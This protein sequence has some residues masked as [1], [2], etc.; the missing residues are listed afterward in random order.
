MPRFQWNKLL[1]PSSPSV[2]NSSTDLDYVATDRQFVEGHLDPVYLLDV[3][4]HLIDF[5]EKLALLLG[6]SKEELFQHYAAFM[7][8]EEVERTLP[9]FH[10]VLQGS[11]ETYTVEVLHK[12]GRPLTLRV[13]NIPKFEHQLIVGVYGIARDITEDK[14]LRKQLEHLFIEREL[15]RDT[16]NLLSFTIQQDGHLTERNSSF[17]KSIGTNV[18]TLDQLIGFLHREDVLSFMTAY[19]EARTSEQ[20]EHAFSF[21]LGRANTESHYIGKFVGH[22]GMVRA[23]FS[24]ETQIVRLSEAYEESNERLQDLYKHSGASIY[25]R[26]LATGQLEFYTDEF[27]SLFGVTPDMMK[28]NPKA[29]HHVIHRNDRQKV[30]VAHDRADAGEEVRMYYRTVKDGQ[31][32]WIEERLVP[33]RNADG[34]VVSVISICY[35]AT[36]LKHQEEQIW[37]LAMYDSLTGLP[38]RSLFL[39]ELED[40]MDTYTHVAVLTLSFNSIHAINRDFG[41]AVGDDWIVATTSALLD[42]IP[43][44]SFVGHLGGD[45]YGILIPHCLEESEMVQYCQPLIRLNDQYIRV[46]PYEWCPSIS[47]GVSRYPEDTDVPVEL[48][49]Y[50]NTA[51]G[52]TQGT[53]MEPIVFYASN[54]NIDSYRRHQLGNDLRRAIEEHELFLEFQPKVDAWSGRIVGAEALVRWQHPEWGRIPPSDFIPLSEE[55]ELHIKLADWVLHETCRCLQAWQSQDLPVVP[56]SINISPKR[57]LHGN[58]AETVIRAL[59]RSN[60]PP[61]LLEI[62]ILETDVLSDNL[63]IHE[64]LDR[65]SDANIR[66][67]LDDFGTGYS[68]LSYLQRYP[69]KTIKIDQQF[70][71][72]LH[73]NKKTQSIV[74]TILF[75]ADEFGM[76]VVV[77]GVETLEQLMILRRLNCRIIQGYLFSRPLDIRNFESA[78]ENRF[79]STTETGP[80]VSRQSFSLDAAVTIHKLHDREVTVGSTPI[81]LTKSSLRSLHFYATVRLPIADTIEL[82]ITL[83]H[84][85]EQLALLVSPNSMI[86]LENGIFEYEASFLETGDAH[87]I[88]IAL[89]ERMNT[90]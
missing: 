7:T 14:Q 42:C 70:A 45:E 11:E 86:E 69:I 44:G 77:E 43:K 53:K 60:I 83:T 46:G 33:K 73:A 13:T 76:D 8:T 54:F 55:T 20:I 23:A 40:W 4:G 31:T 28:K 25:R 56:V 15:F 62:E 2:N 19:E 3:D 10:R 78:L 38:N 89:Q 82:K 74:R 36:R 87:R 37:Q 21:R 27:E 71:R 16:S 12:S 39:R 30:R 81:L 80:H 22:D 68:S 17:N 9:Y 58:F 64:T 57:L 52:R 59:R 49:Q 51:L 90:P 41:Y 6:Y 61:S 88:V 84:R 35:D 67:A 34:A 5:N 48:L 1:K 24:D 72:D 18:T 47:I 26:D 79:L 75:M 65:L 85:G 63:K 66:I 32:N 29:C 50:A